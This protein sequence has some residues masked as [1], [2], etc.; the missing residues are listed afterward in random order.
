MGVGIESNWRLYMNI[1]KEVHNMNIVLFGCGNCGT[2]AYEYFKSAS[3]GDNVVAFADNNCS[4]SYKNLPIY[5]IHEMCNIRFDYIYIYVLLI[6]L[7]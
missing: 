1:I 4:G 6:R 5:S 3:E 2:I 7:Q